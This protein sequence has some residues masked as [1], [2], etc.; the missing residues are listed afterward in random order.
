MHLRSIL[1]TAMIV[2]GSTAG[3][4]ATVSQSYN[5]LLSGSSTQSGYF[6]LTGL[7]G[8]NQYI[9]S[10]SIKAYFVDDG[11][12]EYSH[13]S[14]FWCGFSTLCVT[15]HYEDEIETAVLSSGD[16]SVRSSSTYF[17]RTYWTGAETIG[18][19]TYVYYNNE[20]GYGGAFDSILTLSGSLLDDLNKDLG[21]SWLVSA[22]AG[23]FFFRSI[24]L[25]YET[26]TFEPPVAVPLPGAVWLFGSALA[27]LFGL[28][29]FRRRKQA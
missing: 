19:T 27:G 10:A 14:S 28:N 9:S 18:G 5:T 20:Q 23:D 25:T 4:A 12:L 2:A 15:R 11:D 22:L 16:E 26:A 13:T 7:L 8:E 17:E 6:D 21:I 24:T 1:A 3:H 29:V